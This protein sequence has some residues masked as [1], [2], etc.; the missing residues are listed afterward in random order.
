MPINAF[1]GHSFAEK[2]RELVRK[3]LDFFYTVSKMNIDF[4]WDHAEDAQ[5]KELSV[6]V[7]EKMEGKNLFIGICTPRQG[8]IDLDQLRSFPLAPN[9][10]WSNR[11]NF[12]TKISDWILQEIGFSV[13][14][15]MDVLLLL[16]NGV[17]TPRGIQGDREHIPFERSKPEESF[18]KI[19]EMLSS[20]AK[21]SSSKVSVESSTMN[22][23]VTEPTAISVKQVSS[24]EI[25]ISEWTLDD[26]G[27]SLSQ[28][29]ID[30]DKTKE[31]DIN[32]SFLNS[33]FAADKATVARWNAFRIYMSITWWKEDQF[34][35]LL[36]IAENNPDNQYVFQYIAQAYQEFGEYRQA[37]VYFEKSSSV[38]ESLDDRFD[39][40]SKASLA[41]AK[42]RDKGQ[43][44]FHLKQCI[45]LAKKDQSLIKD[46]LATL[47][48]VL[49]EIGELDD[50]KIFTEALLERTPDDNTRRYSLA[51]EYGKAKENDGAIFHYGLL[52]IRSPN[53]AVWNNLGVALSGEN[54][55]GLAV[56]AYRE[57]EKLDEGTT[58]MGNLAHRFINQGFL[59]EATEISNKAIA[60][61]NYDQNV[62][63]AISSI[64]ETRIKE[65]KEH[66]KLMESYKKKRQ[67]YVG[68]CAKYL[69]D[70]I[71]SLPE[72]WRSSRCELKLSI[73]NDVLQ[74]V[75][76]FEESAPQYSWM[77]KLGSSA[78][79]KE[80]P[81]KN[82]V[83]Y[84]GKIDGSTAKFDYWISKDKSPQTQNNKPDGSGL[85]IIEDNKQKI[86]VYEKALKDDSA[87]TEMTAITIQDH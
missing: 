53:A 10:R 35:E 32:K 68:Y 40:L 49:A 16:E 15:G 60:I 72:N 8:S 23:A 20:L 42:S 57:S 45:S 56:D 22:M 83:L 5:L 9:F 79:S 74:L 44:I 66:A 54:L 84:V 82:Y 86:R 87:F 14:R 21:L 73:E 37:A 28:A 2:D 29:F 48:D 64:K 24:E 12:Q 36:H 3:F 85:M 46:L 80:P 71:Q 17:A 43:A 55:E 18:G 6:K 62:A 33:K 30:N 78:S 27:M 1:V 38:A 39:K 75:G 13:G 25:P 70:N 50:Y 4:H 61:E 63:D 81:V 67:F 47:S 59:D 76:E 52:S 51:S 41:Y 26:Y 7:I 58:A 69:E 31:E 19:L 77:P 11:I 34:D 65:E